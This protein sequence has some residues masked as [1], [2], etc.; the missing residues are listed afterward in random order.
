VLGDELLVGGDDVAARAQRSQH[1]VTGGVRAADQLD[2]DLR[3]REDPLVIALATTQH[4]RDPRPPP[5]C[6]L[7]RLGPA[8]DQLREGGAD[9]PV[10]EEADGNSLSHSSW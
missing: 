6:R 3:I 10:A 7:D 4:P 8:L 2:D 1:V 5:G 9:R